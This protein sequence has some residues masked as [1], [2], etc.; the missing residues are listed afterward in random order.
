[1]SKKVF[2]LFSVLLVLL[3]VVVPISV[4]AQTI[5][6]NQLSKVE[7]SGSMNFQKGIKKSKMVFANLSNQQKK[8]R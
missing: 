3:S 4:S 2:V 7:L 8:Q 5:E 1:M 6:K